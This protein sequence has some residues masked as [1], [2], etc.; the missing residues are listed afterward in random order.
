[1]KANKIGFKLSS[2]IFGRDKNPTDVV[3]IF[4]DGKN[5]S[6]IISCSLP[7][8]PEE[9]YTSLMRVYSLK[10]EPVNICVCG[11][12]CVG[13]GDTEVHIDETDHFVIW[14][15]FLYDH[16]CIDSDVLFIFEKKQY[17][18][19][20]DKILQW[21]EDRR[22]AY[23]IGNIFTIWSNELR[24]NYLADNLSSLCVLKSDFNSKV[25][26]GRDEVL[27]VLK[28]NL[29][30]G[31]YERK[32]EENYLY[33]MCSYKGELQERGYNKWYLEL[34]YHENPHDVVMYIL[35][36]T[37]DDGRIEE[38]L[39]SRNKEW[40]HPVYWHPWNQ[41]QFKWSGDIPESKQKETQSPNQDRRLAS[42]KLL[43]TREPDE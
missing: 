30:D 6:D 14:H 34:G 37:D 5:L 24:F 42:F 16:K 17:Y 19:E 10:D 22:L 21:I 20:V 12:G 28:H 9:L 26:S 32:R 31:S 8:W 41:E 36:K 35:F 23:Y 39:L 29:L 40:F 2:E 4:I 43:W 18:I 25:Y 15:G 11:C 3:E 38:I 13:C 7:L 33:R 27:K 1:M